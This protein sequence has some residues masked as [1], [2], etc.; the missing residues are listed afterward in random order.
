M[1]LLFMETKDY[2]EIVNAKT[3]SNTLSQKLAIKRYIPDN[4]C[5]ALA[6]SFSRL[7]CR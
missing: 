2:V 1:C 3:I 7:C 4:F 6:P 5:I